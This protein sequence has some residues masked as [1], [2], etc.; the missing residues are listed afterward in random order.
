MLTPE[1]NERI[2]ALGPGTPGGDL[3]RRYWHPVAA[4]SELTAERPLKRIKIL[5]EELVLYRSEAGGYGLLGE[6]CSHR[7]TSLAY[8]FV[9]GENLRCPYHG[10]LYNAG[11]RWGDQRFEPA[12]SMMRYTLR[13][14]AYPVEKLG[15]L[16]FAY[17]GPPEKKPL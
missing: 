16:L 4:A 12:Q 17:M 14:P 10:W 1:E 9:E 13:H 3:F 6:H 15:G 8:G 2:T 7:G 11:G 5:G